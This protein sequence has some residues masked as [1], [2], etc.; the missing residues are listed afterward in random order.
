MALILLEQSLLQEVV[1]VA[2]GVARAARE[3]FGDVRPFVAHLHLVLHDGLVLLLRPGLAGDAGL[4]HVMPALVALLGVAVIEVRGD[5]APLLRAYRM[6]QFLQASILL[7]RP[8]VPF[9]GVVRARVAPVRKLG[10]PVV[11]ERGQTQSAQAQEGCRGQ[12]GEL[13]GWLLVMLR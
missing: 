8:R 7:R 13:V 11:I 2:D 9:V 10:V 5:D 6:Y 12:V 3:I 4:E 1:A